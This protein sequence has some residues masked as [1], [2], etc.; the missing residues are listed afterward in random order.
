[1]LLLSILSCPQHPAVNADDRIVEVDAGLADE[2]RFKGKI[3]INDGVGE[4]G[5]VDPDVL[6]PAEPDACNAADHGNELKQRC[7]FEICD[8]L[9]PKFGYC[10]DARGF[11]DA[12]LR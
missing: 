6:D 7:L 1:M 5:G 8:E 11:D 4:P 3:D 12:L 10:H 9:V 2:R